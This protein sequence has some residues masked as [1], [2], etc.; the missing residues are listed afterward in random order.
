MSSIS[1][2]SRWLKSDSP[3]DSFPDPEQALTDPPGLLAI[4]G[5]LS[6]ERLLAAYRR[7]IFPWYDEDTPILWWSPDPRTVLFPNEVHLSRSLKK[8]LRQNRFEVSID[9]AFEDVITRCAKR[10]NDEGTWITSDMTDAYIQLHEA[11]HAHSVETWRDDDLVGGLYGV[12]IGSVF[13]GESMFSEE[14]DAS[15]VALVKLCA[16]CRKKNIELIDCQIASG[17][18]ARMGSRKIMRN[19]F[20]RQLEVLTT[21]PSPQDWSHAPQ[22]TNQLTG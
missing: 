7:G 21:F 15:K 13:F 19:E 6:S 5:D 22:S 9:Q 14:S 10:S 16:I 20:N 2:E 1:I 12:N 8:T 17:H 11:G 18:L 4:G 3:P